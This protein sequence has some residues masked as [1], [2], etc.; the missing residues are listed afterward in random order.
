MTADPPKVVSAVAALAARLE[1][2]A[3]AGDKL[4]DKESLVLVLN[5]QYPGDVGVLSAFFLNYVRG[6]GGVGGIFRGFSWA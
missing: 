5:G 2:R 1:A 4:S 6:N 3:A